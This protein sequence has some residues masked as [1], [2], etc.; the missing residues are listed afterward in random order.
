MQGNRS[1]KVSNDP[2]A[3]VP[4]PLS[5]ATTSSDDLSIATTAA[6]DLSTAT[7]DALS[8]ATSS[9]D[10]DVSAIS[11]CVS[12]PRKRKASSKK[13]TPKAKLAKIHRPVKTPLMKS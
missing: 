8:T 10:H 12:E 7:S 3:I 4:I 9:T 2:T 13:T 5:P 11:L 6:D 1:L